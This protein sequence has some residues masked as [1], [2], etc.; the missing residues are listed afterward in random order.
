[1]VL[2]SGLVFSQAKMAGWSTGYHTTWGGQNTA[3][4]YFKAY[5]HLMYFTGSTNPPSA[6]EGKSFS[7]VVHQN[8]SKAILCIGGWGAAASFE[9]STNSASG[10]AAFIRKIVDGMTSG[11]FDGIDIDW[12]E[13]GGGISGNYTLLL[14][15]LRTALNAIT[16]RPMLTIATADNQVPSAVAVKD[17]VDQMNAMSYWTL[18]GGMAGYMK[19]FTDKGVPKSV[20]GVGYGYDNDGELDINN[21]TDIEAKCKFAIDNGYGGIMIWEVAQAC[22]ACNE[23]TAKYVDKNAVTSV[24]PGMEARL[25]FQQANTLSIVTNSLTGARE[26][27]YSVGSAG[28]DAA[29][30]NLGLYDM[31]GGLVKTLAH[32]PSLP[33]SYALPLDGAAAAGA[34]GAGAQGAFVVKLVSPSGVKAAS[35]LLSR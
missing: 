10:R 6:S 31:N 27:R 12:E 15:E 2:G 32:G 11:G 25:A 29:F 26:I 1:M 7:D 21:P 34:R 17:Y 19:K 5:T 13:E 14:K 3:N 22:S 20:L 4:T 23:M 8:K 9:G 18:A 24:R 35:A 28:G 30:I 33:G 16:P